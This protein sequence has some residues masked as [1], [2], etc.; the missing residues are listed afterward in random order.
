[1]NSEGIVNRE[2]RWCGEGRWG[3]AEGKGRNGR[4]GSGQGCDFFEIRY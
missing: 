1:M 4:M 2:V 3:E